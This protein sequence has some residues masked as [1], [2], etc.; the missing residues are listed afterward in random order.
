MLKYALLIINFLVFFSVFSQSKVEI[1]SR[2]LEVFPLEKLEY[3]KENS[4]KELAFMNFMLDNALEVIEASEFQAST[5][6]FSNVKID[7]VENIN[8][9]KLKLNQQS[10]SSS[11][12][13][14]EDTDLVLAVKSYNA[15]K[16]MFKNEFYKD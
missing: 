1:D 6:Q 16:E 10:D 2:L 15:V 14:I 7:D 5:N 4:P 8:Y 3:L 13:L 12:Y 9:Y 11:Y